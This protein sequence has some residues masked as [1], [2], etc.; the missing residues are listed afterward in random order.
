[1][2]IMSSMVI[3]NISWLVATMQ[4]LQQVVMNVLMVN[5]ELICCHL[6]EKQTSLANLATIQAVRVVG[7]VV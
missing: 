3:L 1:M 5:T 2:I 6:V 4:G 7:V